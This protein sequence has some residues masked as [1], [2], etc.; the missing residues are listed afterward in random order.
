MSLDDFYEVVDAF[1]TCMLLTFTARGTPHARPMAL[2][3]RDHSALWFVSD[4]DSAKVDEM[5]TDRTTVVTFQGSRRW[6]AATGRATVVDDRA[7]I[8]E[9]WSKPMQAWF[10]DGPDDS[11]LVALRVDLDD[12]EYWDISGGKLARFAVGLARSV[13]TGDRIDS[14]EEGDHGRHRL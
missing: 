5:T 2:A 4:R 11:D 6:A 9:L 14:D 7:R 12:G 1:D 13:A 3:G 10:P 8:D